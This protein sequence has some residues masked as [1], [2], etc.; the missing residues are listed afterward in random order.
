MTRT[1][2]LYLIAGR[3]CPEIPVQELGDDFD[4]LALEP[5]VSKPDERML[6]PFYKEEEKTARE[7]EESRK[8]CQQCRS[9]RLECGFERP[10]WACI[11][12]GGQCSLL[13]RRR[14]VHPFTEREHC[15]QSEDTLTGTLAIPGS[16]NSRKDGA[17]HRG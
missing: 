14:K 7:I 15:Q 6:P 5:V 2:L 4:N 10:C 11:T 17:E 13:Q 16:K 12:A 1:I 9:N 3:I 8:Y